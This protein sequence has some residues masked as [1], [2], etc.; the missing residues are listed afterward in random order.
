MLSLRARGFIVVALLLTLPWKFAIK[1]ENPNEVDGAI[2]ELL[3]S[4]QL[5]A[6]LTDKSMEY[7]RII[8]ATSDSC[9][10]WAARISPL[11]YE[12]NLVRRVGAD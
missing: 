11:G 7:T 2:V 9:H 1:P 5:K 4:H 8:E 12:T 10:L 3:D 6:S